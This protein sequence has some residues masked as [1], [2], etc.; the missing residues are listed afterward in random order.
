MESDGIQRNLPQGIVLAS[1]SRNMFYFRSAKQ[2]KGQ[3]EPI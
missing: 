1:N 2:L 3:D